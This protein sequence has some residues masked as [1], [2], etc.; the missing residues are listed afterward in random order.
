MKTIML[1]AAA[2]MSLGM[3]SAFATTATRGQAET[4]VAQLNLDVQSSQAAK[5]LPNQAATTPGVH[6]F[7][8]PSSIPATPLG[9]LEAYA[10]DAAGGA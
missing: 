7:T 2:V 4:R 9:A 5:M 3:T 1:A 6:W 10:T 8:R